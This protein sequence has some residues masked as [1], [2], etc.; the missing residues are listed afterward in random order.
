[1]IKKREGAEEST[2]WSVRTRSGSHA[3]WP[4]LRRRGW[5]TA[6]WRLCLD[7]TICHVTSNGLEEESGNEYG[8]EMN[9]VEGV[10]YRRRG[11]LEGIGSRGLL[12]SDAERLTHLSPIGGELQV[13]NCG[14]EVV[15]YNS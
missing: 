10:T 2:L 15:L 8:T 12:R 7:M 14:V 13:L 6:R 1:M 9:E 4:S 11:S 3:R 5:G